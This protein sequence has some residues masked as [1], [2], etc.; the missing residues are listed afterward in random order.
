MSSNEEIQEIAIGFLRTKN[1]EL[2]AENERLKLRVLELQQI[3]DP[4]YQA[5][6]NNAD[7]G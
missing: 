6:T 7:I 3:L 5:E 4:S 2:E 1:K